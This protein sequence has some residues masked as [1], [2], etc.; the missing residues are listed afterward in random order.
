MALVRVA[1]ALSQAMPKAKR[2]AWPGLALARARA[3]FL[4]QE[5]VREDR[6]ERQ[7]LEMA[8][9]RDELLLTLVAIF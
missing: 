2:L 6:K 3:Y 9:K 4:M 1:R 7:K 5:N 8:E